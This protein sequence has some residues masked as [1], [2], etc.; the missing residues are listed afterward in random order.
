MNILLDTHAFLWGVSG[1]PLGEEAKR[2]FLDQK[3]VLYFSVVSYWEIGIK[4]SLG[5]LKLRNDWR[6]AFD[7]FL[8]INQ[9]HWLPI[10]K[11]HI[12]EVVELPFYHRDPFDR[13]LIAQA[14][15]EHLTIMT[16]DPHFAAYPISTIW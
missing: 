14:L 4:L 6:Q 11:Y 7:D 15:S 13:L 8:Q 10:E 9:I 3:N 1:L 16:R 5:K 2:T 12:W